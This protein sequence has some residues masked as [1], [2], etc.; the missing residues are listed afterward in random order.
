M[1][2]FS[3]H[4]NKLIKPLNQ[5][6]LLLAVSLILGISTKIFQT[7]FEGF[8]AASQISPFDLNKNN[9]L[10]NSSPIETDFYLF[11]F[12]NFDV[13]KNE[14]LVEGYIW[15]NFDKNKI[16]RDLIEKFSFAWQDDLKIELLDKSLIFF[17]NLE[18]NREFICYNIKL[19]FSGELSY[20]LFPLDNHR[21]YIILINKFIPVSKGYFKTGYDNFILNNEIYT[22]GWRVLNKGVNSGY[23]SIE[24]NKKKLEFP[25]AEFYV[26]L[27]NNNLKDFLLIVLPLFIIYILSALLFSIGY[28][29]YKDII[30][31]T[32]TA[33][34]PMILGYKFVIE[35]ISPRVPY[36]ILSDHIFTLFLFL[37]VGIFLTDFYL[38][39][40]KSKGLI[41]LSFHTILIICWLYLL[42]VWA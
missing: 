5:I 30:I 27:M 18:K 11:G 9:I 31:Q 14:F 37:T 42:F 32:F 3:N 19:K 8:E 20:R 17:R 2:N 1:K 34:I 10:I 13:L 29:K 33:V 39:E 15:F 35:F 23:D 38:K 36:F 40:M 26:D 21:L 12:H 22:E 41:L 16:S 28:A 7:K 4:L 6:F 25:C 24:F